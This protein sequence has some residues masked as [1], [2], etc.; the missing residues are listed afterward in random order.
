MK[1]KDIRKIAFCSLMALGLSSCGDSFF[2]VQMDQ[3]I[4][5][6]DAYKNVQDVK[7]GMIG[8]YYALGQY[9]FYGR[10]VVAIDDLC[11]D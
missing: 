8:A 2:D 10:N 11:S 4:E 3:N 1:M 7:N 9:S 5:T 6:N